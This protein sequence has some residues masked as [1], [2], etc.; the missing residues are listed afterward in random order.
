[1]ENIVI[2]EVQLGEALKVFPKIIEF[3]RKEAGTVDYCKERIGNSICLI[4][5]AYVNNDNAGYLI[6]Y[7]KES[8]FYCWCVGVSPEF[9]RLGLLSKMMEEYEDFAKKHNFN[10][11]TIK[12]VNDKRAMLAYLVK[13]NWYFTEV[14]EKN[15]ITKNEIRLEKEL[16]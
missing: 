1:M 10:K 13:N 8:D 4:L 7:E 14:L 6:A 5:A 12:T 16:R 2:K 11:V 3:D 15:D 9:R